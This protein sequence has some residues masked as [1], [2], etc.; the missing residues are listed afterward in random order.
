MISVI[1]KDMDNNIIRRTDDIN[2]EVFYVPAE[3]RE[4]VS[5]INNK[6]FLNA[7]PYGITVSSVIDEGK[8]FL[9]QFINQ[10]A[11]NYI[12][13]DLSEVLGRY[14]LELCPDWEDYGFFDIWRE[15][16]F[17]KEPKKFREEL[18]FEDVLVAAVIHSVF[19]VGGLIYQ[20]FVDATDEFILNQC[21]ME[22]IENSYLSVGF[23]QNNKWVYGNK[24]FCESNNLTKDNVGTFPFDL[25]NLK[26]LSTSKEELKQILNEVLNRER[27][28]F[29][30][31]IQVQIG[32][33]ELWLRQFVS[34]V[35]YNNA[36]AIQIAAFF[37]NEEKQ[38]EE[39]ILQMEHTLKTIQKLG[40]LAIGH[41]EETFV[42]WSDE[43][44]NIFEV[45]P[46]EKIF[47]INHVKKSKIPIH[48]ASFIPFIL[49][50]DLMKLKRT[51]MKNISQS[52]KNFEVSFRIRTGKGNIKTI[53][54]KLTTFLSE[55][56]SLKGIGILQD[57]TNETNDKNELQSILNEFEETMQDLQ[58]LQEKYRQDINEK[59][60][61]IS[62]AHKEIENNLKMIL[63]ILTYDSEI[64]SDDY[65]NVIKSTQNRINSLALIHNQL[66]KSEDMVH[67]RGNEYITSLVNYILESYSSN[68]QLVTDLDDLYFDMDIMALL[69]LII[70]ESVSNSIEHGFPNGEEGSIFISLK[71]NN[72]MITFIVGDNGVGFP[73]NFNLNESKH[74]GLS[75][76]EKSVKQMNGT[77][78]FYNDNGSKLKVE[79]KN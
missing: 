15:V 23:V 65:E 75:T 44:Y 51:I 12:K 64:N 70:N 13:A 71:E 58:A 50:R 18:Y 52:D 34:P 1:L 17:T 11:L 53:L 56:N 3:I 76:I 40:K 48:Y 60:T 22:S 9:I 41:R 66:F 32:N 68:I 59:N 4:E 61:L 46:E 24:V 39:K 62:N 29:S 74:I 28:F 8:D 79:F 78:S 20:T 57:V 77:F 49:K 69:S 73:K 31:D 42:K 54:F 43:I 33:R 63:D 55:K 5:E 2:P 16:Y 37:I 27:Y 30:D 72:G 6:N 7:L 21:R 26:T 36:P 45:S 14:F 25:N 38:M 10:N 47:D 35:T 19:I 67:I